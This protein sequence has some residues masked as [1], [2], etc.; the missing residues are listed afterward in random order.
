M[1]PLQRGHVV[2]VV[3]GEV[4]NGPTRVVVL[5]PVDEGRPLVGVLVLVLVGL[6]GR[7]GI[8]QPNPASTQI[9]RMSAP[10]RRTFLD[11]ST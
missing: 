3:A 10:R 11:C 5:N 4:G 2:V 7:P 9:P 6:P 1:A 8:V